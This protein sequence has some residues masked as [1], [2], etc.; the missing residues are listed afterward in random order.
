ML[1]DL[2]T[3]ST[4]SDGT[5]A[6]AQVMRAA[7][8][9]GLDVVGLADHDSTGGW[10]EAAAEAASLGLEFVPGI[11]VSCQHRG[12]NIHLLAFWPDPDHAGIQA[13]MART[14]DARIDRAKEIVARIAADYPITWEAVEQRAGGSDTVGRPHIADVMVAAGHFPNRDAVFADVLKNGT[15]YYVPHYAPDVVEATTALRDAGGVPVFAH[16]GADARGRIVSDAVIES[17]AEAGLVGLEIDH[18]DHSDEQR[19][20]LAVI[21]ERLGLVRTGA[22][23]YHGTGKQNRLGE[24][25]TTP[26]AYARLR[27]ARG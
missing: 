21:A 18:R 26:D 12:T 23:D 8:E 25:T 1:I 14:R 17:M 19:D 6:P 9:A 3:H 4:V 22:S 7:N 16:P 15:K 24:N 11:E 20:R 10:D 2:H 13:M 27:A 5:E